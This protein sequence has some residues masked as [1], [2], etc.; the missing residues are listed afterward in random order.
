MAFPTLKILSNTVKLNAYLWGSSKSQHG[1]YLKEPDEPSHQLV[2]GNHLHQRLAVGFVLVG[3]H[4]GCCSTGSE[5]G[6]H[7]KCQ[8][9]LGRV[10]ASQLGKDIL[11]GGTG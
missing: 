2:V 4:A 1:V 9:G 5:V 8:V 10:I 11:F 7:V 3:E 6:L